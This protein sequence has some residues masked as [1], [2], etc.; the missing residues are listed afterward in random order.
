MTKSF[1]NIV[2]VHLYGVSS[3]GKRQCLAAG[4]SPNVGIGFEESM[5]AKHKT[6]LMSQVSEF[7]EAGYTGFEIEY[8]KVYNETE[9]VA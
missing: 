1:T 5:L 2:S 9:E 3:K 8:S 6:W 7:R 4:Q